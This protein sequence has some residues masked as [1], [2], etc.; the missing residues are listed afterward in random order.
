MKRTPGK[1]DVI[2]VGIADDHKLFKTGMK[3]ALSTFKD[4][5]ITVEAEN[6]SDLLEKL[7]ISQP[8]VIL[9]D[10][11]MSVMDGITVLPMIKQQYPRIKVIILS[12][13]NDNSLI[14][15][16][17]AMGACSYLT[18]TDEPGNMYTKISQCYKN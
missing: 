9:L 12:M 18:K 14:S 8:D 7:Q 2:R 4:I 1:N 16:L 6:G 3:M 5:M 10:L 13:N 17:L 11:Q 15:K